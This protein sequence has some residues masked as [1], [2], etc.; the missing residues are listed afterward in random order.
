M[1]VRPCWPSGLGGVCTF[2]T[3]PDWAEWRCASDVPYRPRGCAAG[4][5]RDRPDHRPPFPLFRT[6]TVEGPL[7]RMR[8][9][10]KQT[11]ML[12]KQTILRRNK[13][14]KRR[15]EWENEEEIGE[16]HQQLFF[17]KILLPFQTTLSFFQKQ[18]TRSNI[19]Y[20]WFSLI[21]SMLIE[22]GN[23]EY[24]VTKR[25]HL[26]LRNGNL[27]NFFFFVHSVPFSHKFQFFI[28]VILIE[29]W[30]WGL[31]NVKI[32]S[33]TGWT[34]FLGLLGRHRH[35]HT[36]IREDRAAGVQK[37]D[38]QHGAAVVE[39]E[40]RAYVRQNDPTLVKSQK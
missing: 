34:V 18:N 28:A 12:Y 19:K 3:G 2:D 26:D 40:E 32:W 4:R 20:F 22:M 8:N 6:R 31:K 15:E 9:T 11:S 30:I 14:Q 27:L 13:T 7:Q 29:V 36:G 10:M 39:T 33:H 21:I 17:R 5:R 24:F 16:T 35:S 23:L 38:G 25:K 1:W 37:V